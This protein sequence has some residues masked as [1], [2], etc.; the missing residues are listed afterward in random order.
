MSRLALALGGLFLASLP[1]TARGDW[2]GACASIESV[3]SSF[4]EGRSNTCTCA[5]AGPTLTGSAQIGPLTVGLASPGDGAG[6]DLVCTSFLILSGYDMYVPGGTSV[7]VQDQ[8]VN[9][10]VLVS[11]CDSSSCSRRWGFLWSIGS[12]NCMLKI[13]D[14]AGGHMSYK[15]TG[16]NC[17]PPDGSAGSREALSTSPTTPQ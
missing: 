11:T 16:E 3:A 8:F 2:E 9:D 1:A 7:V 13:S 4:V 6:A 17:T 14:L 5:G 12:A 10:Q 15:I